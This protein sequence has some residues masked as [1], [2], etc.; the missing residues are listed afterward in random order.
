MPSIGFIDPTGTQRTVEATPGWSL[1]EAAVKNG[2]PGV[3]AECGGALACATCHVYV[4]PEWIDRVGALED[5]LEREMLDG[6]LTAKE[7]GSRLSCQ[8]TVTDEL[9]G[10]TVR[11][12][13]PEN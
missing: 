10:L 5:E 11:V 9:D 1:M 2:V 7:P 13:P 12:P 4:E 8:V 6:T 3:L